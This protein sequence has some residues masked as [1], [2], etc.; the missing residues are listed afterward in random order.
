MQRPEGGEMSE[1]HDLS[2]REVLRKAAYVAPMILSL[3]AT[4][5]AAKSGSE[6]E[7][8]KEQKSERPAKPKKARRSKQLRR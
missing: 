3:Q 1:K 2:R 6:K 8:W 4:S 7:R 5:A